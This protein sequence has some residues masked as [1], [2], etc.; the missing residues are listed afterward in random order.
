MTVRKDRTATATMA[1]AL[2]AFTILDRQLDAGHAVKLSAEDETGTTRWTVMKRRPL[3]EGDMPYIIAKEVPTRRGLSVFFH[4][5]NLRETLEVLIEEFK[6][7]EP[8]EEPA[9]KTKTAMIAGLRKLGWTITTHP[10]EG[11]HT[12]RAKRPGSSESHCDETLKTLYDRIIAAE[13]KT[14]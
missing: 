8:K 10:G 14:P 11:V 12:W 5:E 9:P 3:V 1:T 4:R 13:E 2:F 7:F 6:P